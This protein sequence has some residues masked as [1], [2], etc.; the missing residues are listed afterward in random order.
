MTV[1]GTVQNQAENLIEPTLE[2][3]RAVAAASAPQLPAGD[4]SWSNITMVNAPGE[5]S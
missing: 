4:Q 3:T 5:Q 1:G 2:S